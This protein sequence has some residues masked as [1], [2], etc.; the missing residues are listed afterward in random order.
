MSSACGS[1]VTVAGDFLINLGGMW[2]S[3]VRLR[4][5]AAQDVV[6]TSEGWAPKTITPD[7]FFVAKELA[8]RYEA[9]AAEL[10]MHY[11]QICDVAPPDEADERITAHHEV[12]G[13]DES[14]IR[15]RA[16]SPSSAR[17]RYR[18]PPVLYGVTARR[19]HREALQRC[20][21]IATP[22]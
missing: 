4:N 18:Q 20:P 14:A 1:I 10:K 9:A 2:K 22:L 13:H 17:Q 15:H 5:E 19:C 21:F 7:H 6:R 12:S 11:I 3:D 8:V 16:D